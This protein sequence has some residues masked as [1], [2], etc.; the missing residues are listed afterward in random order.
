M[1]FLTVGRPNGRMWNIATTLNAA[2]AAS[3]LDSPRMV[4][5]WNSDR[6]RRS[7]GFREASQK[8]RSFLVI[9]IA[10]M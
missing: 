3:D 6:L 10:G 2:S 5:N 1:S 9:A 8:N 7:N 4:P